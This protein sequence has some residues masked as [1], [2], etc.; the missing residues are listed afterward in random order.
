MIYDL[1]WF[2]E[3]PLW[4]VRWIMISVFFFLLKIGMPWLIQNSRPSKIGQTLNDMSHTAAALVAL[5]KLVGRHPFHQTS[6]TGDGLPLTG[7]C[8]QWRNRHCWKCSA[9]CRVSKICDVIC[10]CWLGSQSRCFSS[11][12]RLNRQPFYLVTYPKNITHRY[13]RHELLLV[14]LGLLPPS[15]HSPNFPDDTASNTNSIVV[16]CCT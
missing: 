7:C 14:S 15:P 4:G 9:S 3:S 1:D 16:Q 6:L 8:Y 5:I 11:K 13:L 12:T 2:G 10:L